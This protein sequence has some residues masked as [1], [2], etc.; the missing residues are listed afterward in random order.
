MD[1]DSTRPEAVSV[2]VS[3][4]P[5]GSWIDLVA[6]DKLIV[7][8]FDNPHLLALNC[9]LEKGNGAARHELRGDR[10]TSQ[11]G[12]SFFHPANI[13]GR[14]HDSDLILTT[15]RLNGNHVVTAMP[16]ETDV[17]FVNLDLTDPLD[18]RAQ[19]ILQA[20]GGQPQ[21]RIDEAIVADDGQQRLF[22]VQPSVPT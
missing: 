16:V 6:G 13:L 18:R 5:Y 1:L 9:E 11:A 10:S 4:A 17:Q 8:L 12:K 22:V 15:L 14:L 20:I 19:V 3:I 7:A 21:K 2:S